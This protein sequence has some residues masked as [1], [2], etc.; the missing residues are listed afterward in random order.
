MAAFLVGRARFCSARVDT[1]RLPDA[2]A[3]VQNATR[4]KNHGKK[5]GKTMGKKVGK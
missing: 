2:A 5:I 3:K 1:T 4:E